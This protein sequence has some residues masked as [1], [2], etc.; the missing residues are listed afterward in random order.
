MFELDIPSLWSFSYH[1]FLEDTSR[2]YN[3]QSHFSSALIGM[4]L[5]PPPVINTANCVAL[6]GRG[7][8]EHVPEECER[9]IHNRLFTAALR[10]CARISVLDDA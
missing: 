9:S 8:T 4:V 2:G 1:K 10:L 6:V 5:A 3:E 7:V